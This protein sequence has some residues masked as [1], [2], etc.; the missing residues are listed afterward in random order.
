MTFPYIS[1]IK[2]NNCFAYKHF[3]IPGSEL[4][5]FKHIVLTGKNGSGKTTILNRTAYLLTQLQ[6]GKTKEVLVRGLKSSIQANKNHP[7]RTTWEQQIKEVEDIDLLHLGG[8]SNLL[9]EHSDAY[10]FSFFKALRKV[11]LKQVSTVTKEEDFLSNLKKQDKAEDFTNQ[12]KQYLVN[13]KVYEAFDYMNSKNERID[14]NKLFF[15][16]LTETLKSIFNDEKLQLSFVQESFEFYIKFKDGRQVTFNQLSDGFSAF[17]SILMDLFMR[18]DLIRKAKSDYSLEPEGIVLIDEPETH[19]HL[20]MQYEI[21]P[22]IN[23]LFPKIQLIIATH[24]PAIISSIKNAIVYDLTSKEEVADWILG[25]SYSE[26][27]IKHFGLDNEYSPVADKILLE[28]NKAVKEKDANKLKL[29]FVE[30]ENYLTPSLK[31]EIE[32]QIIHINA[33]I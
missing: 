20:S 26:L 19:F 14:Q 18:T 32:S 24:S 5:D 29:I 12:F 6:D 15:D 25:S 3:L 31:L 17:L 7:M 13:K 33:S 10:I 4:K 23:R 28:I 21:L 16:N 9:M 30:N 22:L 27:M 2:V 1:Q 8:T 11:E